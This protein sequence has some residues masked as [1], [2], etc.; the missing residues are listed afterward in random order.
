MN[1]VITWT[2]VTIFLSAF[3]ANA[4]G[5]VVEVKPAE[6]NKRLASVSDWNQWRGPG[7]DC[8]LKNADWP[9]SIDETTLNEKWSKK[10]GASYSGPIVVGDKVFTTETHNR[11]SEI[12]RAF[13]RNTGKEIWKTDWLG[14]MTVPF[15]AAKN[16]SWIRSTPAYDSGKLYVG[17]IVGVLVCLDAKTG[18]EV[19]KINF[20]EKFGTTKPSF[21]F[22]CSPLVDGEFVYIQG[23]GGF[24]KINKTSGELVWRGAVDGGGMMGSAFSSPVIA[25]VAGKRQAI[26]QS[27]ESLMGIDL[28]NSSQLWSIPVKTYRGMN[29]LT[30][31]IYND[32]VFVSTYGGTTQLLN[33][34]SSGP[35]FTV[36]KKWELGKQGYMSSP[37]VVDG[38]AYLTM[39]NR[40]IACFDLESG[41]LKWNSPRYS[42]Y[43]SLISNGKKILALDSSGQLLLFKANPEKFELLGTRRVSENSWAHLGIRGDQVF[44]RDLN[45][46][47]VFDWKKAQ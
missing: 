40:T 43:S 30:P 7:R 5:Q 37:V 19:W 23:G 9:D 11:K 24:C 12:V 26:I 35:A 18:Q 25:T 36:N 41:E 15:F 44:V 31:S 27:R 20:P 22:V 28:E 29:I 8:I 14:S 45:A 38:H 4:K 46:I 42:D 1:N 6:S 34:A 3:C 47:K 17:S 32:G 16:G 2:L 21:G 33:V 10:L 13:D 39:R